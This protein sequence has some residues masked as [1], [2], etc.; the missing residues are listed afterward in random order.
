MLSI[1]Q[2]VEDSVVIA[3]TPE[4]CDD[5]R[6][7]VKISTLAGLCVREKVPVQG[8]VP[9]RKGNLVIQ[10]PFVYSLSCASK[11]CSDVEILEDCCKDFLILTD[12][13]WSVFSNKG[14][15]AEGYSGLQVV[16]TQLGMFNNVRHQ[17]LRFNL[18]SIYD[19]GLDT[20]LEVYQVSQQ[21]T[22]DLDTHLDYIVLVHSS[23]GDWDYKVLGGFGIRDYKMGIS[24]EVQVRLI[25]RT[26]G[27]GAFPSDIRDIIKVG[28]KK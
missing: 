7:V 3:K 15:Q 11:F 13:S 5:R 10:V 25:M 1:A 4:E 22:G 27:Y 9:I 21:I 6:T 23:S 14:Y 2:V 24:S 8:V 20:P 16:T 26:N 18:K 19:F 12:V 17:C 28:V